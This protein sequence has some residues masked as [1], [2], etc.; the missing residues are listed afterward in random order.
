MSTLRI[1]ICSDGTDTADIPARVGGLLARTCQATVTLLGIAE[2]PQDEAPLRAALESEAQML[3]GLGVTQETVL[4]AGEPIDEIL[5]QT[6]AAQYDLVIIG[7]R[8]QQT[9]GRHWRSQRTYEVMKAIPPPVLMAVSE[10]QAFSKLLVC[11]GGKRYIEAAVHLTG[12]LAACA[13]ASVTLLH[14][15]AEPPAIYA[16]LVRLEE[17]V[18]A[19]LAAGSELG[20]NLRMQKLSLEKLGVTVEVRVRHGIVLDQVFAE[21]HE[22]G[23]DMIV[24]G[25]AD[26]RGALRHYIMGDLTKSIVDRAKCAVL[27]A[28]PAPG[29]RSGLLASLKRIFSSGA[30][31]GPP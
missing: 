16:D 17:D 19:L 7:A 27:V 3:A 12:Q 1:L 8:T 14:V 24:T 9:S 30:A 23:Y 2:E 25:S 28:R 15:M 13:G 5:K 10:V 26:A 18:E 11:T 6:S 21:L 31:S 20:E 22:G 4:R 29:M